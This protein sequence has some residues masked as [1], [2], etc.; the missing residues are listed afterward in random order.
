MPLILA[1]EPDPRQ[2]AQITAIARNRVGAELRLAATTEQALDVIGDRVPDLVLVPALLSPQDDAALAA[3]LRVIAAAAHVRTLT[4]PVLASGVR[5]T[6]AGGMLAKWRKSKPEAPAPDGCDPAVFAEEIS[7]YLREAAAEREIRQNASFDDASSP[8]YQ[9]AEAAETTNA[10]VEATAFQAAAPVLA[11]E[12]RLVQPPAYTEPQFFDERPVFEQ[13]PVFEEPPVFEDQTAFEERPILFGKQFDDEPLDDEPV[14]FFEPE[15]VRHEAFAATPRDFFNTMPASEASVSEVVEPELIATVQEPE[16]VSDAI[17]QALAP[18]LSFS[19]QS[20]PVEAPA[21]A[22]SH[23]FETM[24]ALVESPIVATEPTLAA[25]P[26]PVIETATLEELAEEE[27]DDSLTVSVEPSFSDQE[28]VIAAAAP[29]VE[30]DLSDELG[31][32]D[33]P[34]FELEAGDATAMLFED[35]A[36]A[37]FAAAP[38]RP[39]A[40]IA[41]PIETDFERQLAAYSE[42]A[43]EEGDTIAEIFAALS[44]VD[45]F[46]VRHEPPAAPAE[47]SS[48]APARHIEF[49]TPT[50]LTGYRWPRI[51]GMA[52]EMADRRE[53][54]NDATA[55]VAAAAAVVVAAATPRPARPAQKA[56]THKADRPEWS[57]LIASLRQDIERLRGGNQAPTAVP[58]AAR[59]SQPAPPRP[60]APS[61]EASATKP[62]ARGRKP[63]QDEWGFFDPEQCGFAALVAKLSE[64]TDASEETELHAH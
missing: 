22:P 5:H 21:V 31:D 36:F 45:Q 29:W 34:V 3:A 6:S 13:T 32:G 25:M 55:A 2:A 57:E 14:R 48:V 42:P 56:E 59:T 62:K 64:I 1:I 37:A 54:R 11:E 51:E 61:D 23:A 35:P 26:E 40:P 9:T 16:A 15:V 50:G 52:A 27:A 20:E 4:I 10:A 17:E 19:T 43:A 28:P 60:S 39:T 7:S 63:I 47:I 49:F 58:V 8:A 41:K 46:I 44:N 53:H 30:F 38:S 12:P 24:K 33:E 18:E